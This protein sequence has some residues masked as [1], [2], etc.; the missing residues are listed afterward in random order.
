[1]TTP[2]RAEAL[3]CDADALVTSGAWAEGA[4]ALEAAAK[5][6][7]HAGRDYDQARCLQ[8]AATLRRSSGDA[9]GAR[10]LVERASAVGS[11]DDSLSVSILAERA[12][13]AM[14]QN[15]YAD[16]VAAWTSCIDKARSLGASAH[17]KIAL[18][19][20]RAACFLAVDAA[21]DA[22][23]DF[24]AA[25][26]LAEDAT[27]AGFLRAE[28]ARLL[29]D[30]GDADGAAHALP[31]GDSADA[32]LRAETRVVRARLASV[33]GDARGA[34]EHAVAARAAALEAIAPIPFLAASIQLAEALDAQGARAE[35]YSVLATA[36]ATLS[37][38]L[39]ADVARSWIE[40]VLEALRLRWGDDA[41]AR[42]KQVH[43]DTRR[44]ATGTVS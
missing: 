42:A 20:R 16:A 4:V 9:E 6:H 30:R 35:S 21:D 5:H 14:T 10:A 8:L 24:G 18:L 23:A 19:R 3:M 33:N 2:D 15:R 11:G 36:W 25:C 38:L 13:T 43:D 28:Q 17:D 41:F 44:A 26:N 31:L 27:M 34:G 22:D 12:E 40:P 32:H 29:L 39:G 37:D 7:A 1:M